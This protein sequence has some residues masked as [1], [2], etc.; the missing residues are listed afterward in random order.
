MKQ[1]KKRKRSEEVFYVGVRDPTEV[2]RNLLESA[3]EAVRFLQRYEKLKEIREQKFQAMLQLD[4]EVKDLRSLVG[5]LKK[6]FLK[7]KGSI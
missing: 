7:S 3:R 5:K 6:S 2:R 4:A 1:K